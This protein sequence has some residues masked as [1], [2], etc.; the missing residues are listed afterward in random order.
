MKK[1][2][3]II[4]SVISVV[5]ILGI[6]MNPIFFYVG[7]FLIHPLMHLFMG[8]NHSQHKDHNKRTEKNDR[9]ECGLK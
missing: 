8:H 2:I 1:K 3:L 4:I 7:I 5:I 9:H 6:F